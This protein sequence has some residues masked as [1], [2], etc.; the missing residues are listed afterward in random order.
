MMRHFCPSRFSPM[1]W[2]LWGLR[3]G[4][5]AAAIASMG[6]A[7]ALIGLQIGYLSAIVG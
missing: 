6:L 7:M 4:F 1:A 2:T 5:V 3:W